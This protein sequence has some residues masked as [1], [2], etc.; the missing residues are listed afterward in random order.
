MS[1]SSSA[2]LWEGKNKPLVHIA[3]CRPRS[4]GPKNPPHAPDRECCYW[5]HNNSNTAD[6]SVFIE[7]QEHRCKMCPE[8]KQGKSWEG[9][10]CFGVTLKCFAFQDWCLQARIWTGLYHPGHFL[11]S[12]AST[13]SC[14]LMQFLKRLLNALQYNQH[15]NIEMFLW[16][17]GLVDNSTEGCKLSALEPQHVHVCANGLWQAVTCLHS[18]FKKYGSAIVG[19]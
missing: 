14:L 1:S 18:W 2:N 3:V 11:A 16:C 10:F 5:R 19:C 15:F 12:Q 13:T 8:K 6:P 9:S 7:A 17:S 4:C